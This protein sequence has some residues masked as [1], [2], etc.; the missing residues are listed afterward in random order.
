MHRGWFSEEFSATKSHTSTRLRDQ[1]GRCF[2]TRAHACFGLGRDPPP[3]GRGVSQAPATRSR[4]TRRLVA[5]SRP[6]PTAGRVVARC[7]DGRPCGRGVF[8]DG[9]TDVGTGPSS[10]VGD[11]AGMRPR[12]CDGPATCQLVPASLTGGAKSR[13]P[14]AGPPD[15]YEARSRRRTDT[16]LGTRRGAR[17]QTDPPAPGRPSLRSSV[18]PAQAFPTAR[19]EA[20][21]NR[22]ETGWPS[23]TPRTRR[24]SGA[25]VSS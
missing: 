9:S 8:S 10:V 19:R 5:W 1:P 2:A 11:V 22:K 17:R 21:Q 23:S 24:H 7:R 6:L 3:L 15:Q 4:D 13:C 20:P 25:P 18:M 16:W 12:R 14:T